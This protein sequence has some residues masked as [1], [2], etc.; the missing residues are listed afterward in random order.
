M[1][2]YVM[3]V[4]GNQRERALPN[5]LPEVAQHSGGHWPSSM[6]S[7]GWASCYW[8]WRW[9]Y[10]PYIPDGLPGPLCASCLW[11]FC[12]NQRPPWQPDALARC[13]RNLTAVLRPLLLPEDAV[14]IIAAFWCQTICLDEPEILRLFAY[15]MELRWRFPANL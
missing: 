3:V 12:E 9:E 4:R 8:C 11:R 7:L 6:G 5:P 15:V 14:P 10:N 13:E 1:S 2:V